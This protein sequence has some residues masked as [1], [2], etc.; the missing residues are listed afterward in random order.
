[1]ARDYYIFDEKYQQEVDAYSELADNAS[2]HHPDNSWNW[3]RSRLDFVNSPE[4]TKLS[5][6]EQAMSRSA[7]KSCL[8]E[9][10][11]RIHEIEGSQDN[12]LMLPDALYTI[13]ADK[14]D[15]AILSGLQGWEV[16]QQLREAHPELAKKLGELAL[17]DY[18]KLGLAA[19]KKEP[20]CINNSETSFSWDSQYIDNLCYFVKE[21]DKTIIK[22][23]VGGTGNGDFVAYWKQFA[24]SGPVLDPSGQVRPFAPNIA[25]DII[26]AYHSVESSIAATMAGYLARGDGEKLEVVKKEMLAKIDEADLGR[27]GGAFADFGY[28]P[29]IGQDDRLPRSNNKTGDVIGDY[30]VGP[31]G[32]FK[33]GDY[34]MQIV[35]ADD[36]VELRNVTKKRTAR[37]KRVRTIVDHRM[38]IADKDIPAFVAT[39]AAASAGRTSITQIRDAIANARF[40]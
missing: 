25:D 39:M 30:V 36:G 2:I 29:D 15:A 9:Y 10:P 27:G 20:D 23:T 31:P 12:L 26:K 32:R 21:D 1:M 18:V 19:L 5:S 4:F 8:E 16:E 24:A 17:D 38:P 7:L 13:R 3:D 28:H 11:W 34:R 33:D 40:A 6:S 37:S 14:S 22:N 35:C